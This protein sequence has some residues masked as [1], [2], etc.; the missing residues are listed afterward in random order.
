[1]RDEAIERDEMPNLA[2][3]KCELPG[4]KQTECWMTMEPRYNTP[5]EEMI[6][7]HNDIERINFFNPQRNNEQG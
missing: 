4:K 3:E 6:I 1:M 7:S 5:L 2:T